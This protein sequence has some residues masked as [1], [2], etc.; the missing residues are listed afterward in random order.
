MNPKDFPKLTLEQQKQFQSLYA[1]P[2]NLT[3]RDLLI[4]TPPSG[5]LTKKY[6]FLKDT[7]L[8]NILPE[9]FNTVAMIA[10]TNFKNGQVIEGIY[11]TDGSYG[12]VEFTHNNMKFQAP[13]GNKGGD[14]ILNEVKT[15]STT[16]KNKLKPIKTERGTI[17]NEKNIIIGILVLGGIGATI[18]ILKWKKII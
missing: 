3:A 4:G 6:V 16:N 1:D 10:P 11:K 8:G 5:N 18:A 12:Y 15:N 7:L 13:F 2:F 14:D 17:F 9:G